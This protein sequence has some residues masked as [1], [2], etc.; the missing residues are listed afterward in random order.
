MSDLLKQVLLLYAEG[1]SINNIAKVIN[2]SPTY[3]MNVLR[4]NGYA[5][6]LKRIKRTKLLR[7]MKYLKPYLEKARDGKE[8][9]FTWKQ[10]SSEIGKSSITTRKWITHLLEEGMITRQDYCLLDKLKYYDKKKEG[11]T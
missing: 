4:S 5:T 10:F 7:L 6:D 11:K 2:K 3:V 8:F 1:H 9:K